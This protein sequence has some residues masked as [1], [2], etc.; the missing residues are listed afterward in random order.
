MPHSARLVALDVGEKR[1]GVAVG[2]MA[3][4]I[5]VV[6]PAISVNGHELDAI[7][8]LVRDENADLVVVGYPRNMAGEPTRQ[9]AAV[10]QFVARLRAAGLEVAFQDESLTSVE[11]EQLLAD[12]RHGYSKGDIDSQAAAL[13]LRDYMETPGR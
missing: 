10:E 3:I 8:K 9:T 7:T 13:I 1:I 4:K 12:S 2:D 6:R 5:P 11:A